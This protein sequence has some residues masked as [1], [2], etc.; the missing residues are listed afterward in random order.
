MWRMAR[1]IWRG[2]KRIARKIGDF[3]ARLL[4][5]VLYFV[6][7]WPFALAV[8][9]GSDPLAIKPGAQTGWRPRRIELGAEMDRAL[10]QF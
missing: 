9:W 7:L 4:L 1:S 8:R 5:E 3:Q 2:W 6:L 10:R